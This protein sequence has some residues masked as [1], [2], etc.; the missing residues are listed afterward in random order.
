M[1]AVVEIYSR[2]IVLKGV[3]TKMFNSDKMQKEKIKRLKHE[4][5]RLKNDIRQLK[6]DIKRLE[7]K[8]KIIEQTKAEYEK[9]IADA[10]DC[11]KQYMKLM[12]KMKE[13]YAK[14][15]KET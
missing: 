14:M 2:P 3:I 1:W 12:E 9:A 4:N 10:R 8:D 6:A 13:F 5:S 11:K 15:K 7:E